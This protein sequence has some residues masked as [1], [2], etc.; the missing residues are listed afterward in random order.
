MKKRGRD[1]ERG[2]GRK[3]DEV[4][5][6]L[7][8]EGMRERWIERVRGREGGRERRKRRPEGIRNVDMK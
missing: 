1:R 7:D 6:R 8:R 4:G 3:R 2:G 5:K